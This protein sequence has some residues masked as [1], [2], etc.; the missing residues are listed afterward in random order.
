MRGKENQPVHKPEGKRERYGLSFDNIEN[1]IKAL[2]TM[3]D[4]ANKGPVEYIPVSDGDQFAILMPPWVYKKFRPIL[5]K[6]EIT[7]KEVDVVS[8]TDLSLEERAELRKKQARY[9]DK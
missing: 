4:L 8:I 6:R 2:K 9:L 3:H 5:E 1:A 7:F